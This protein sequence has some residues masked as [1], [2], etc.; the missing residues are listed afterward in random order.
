MLKKLYIF[1]LI[2]FV[3]AGY[4]IQSTMSDSSSNSALKNITVYG[5]LQ[6]YML[7][8]KK[9]EQIMFWNKR[10]KTHVYEAPIEWCNM[11]NRKNIEPKQLSFN[12]SEQ[13]TLAAIELREVQTIVAPELQDT[14][15]FLNSNKTS[16]EF[17]L[18]KVTFRGNMTRCYLVD[19]HEK[20]F[21][22]ER[23]GNELIDLEV[24]IRSIK[25]LTIDG[26][27]ATNKECF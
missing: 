14:V 16:Q 1:I 11:E 7:P 23:S 18:I 17:I 8:E 27:S 10:V 24:P 20:L 3:F 22:K 25:L 9:I 15:L 12:P 2:F 13:G 19:K 5:S 6:T 26:Y 21:C 4:Y